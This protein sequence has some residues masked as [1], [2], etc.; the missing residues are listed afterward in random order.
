MIAP[1]AFAVFG[2]SPSAVELPDGYCTSMPHSAPVVVL[3]A[4]DA[5]AFRATL[6]VRFV[7]FTAR[8]KT[9]SGGSVGWFF[10]ASTAPEGAADGPLESQARRTGRRCT[11]TPGDDEGQD[12]QALHLAATPEQSARLLLLRSSDGSW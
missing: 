6:V 5:R 2:S 4:T 8:S 3:I 12:Q 9:T 1:P 10:S 11:A 7:T